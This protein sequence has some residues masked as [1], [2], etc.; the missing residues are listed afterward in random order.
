MAF[1]FL[2]G[3][4]FWL[5]LPAGAIMVAAFFLPGGTAAAGW[6]SY[7]PLSTTFPGGVNYAGRNPYVGEILYQPDPKATKREKVAEFLR[8]HSEAVKTVPTSE[9][10]QTSDGLEAPDRGRRVSDPRCRPR[11]AHRLRTMC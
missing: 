1:P 3:M 10:V 8:L 5:A 2:N 4:A 7:P 11:C 9:L 6:T